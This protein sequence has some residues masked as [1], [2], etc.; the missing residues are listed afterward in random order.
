[1]KKLALVAAL[2]LFPAGAGAQ[3]TTDPR[4][5]AWLGCWELVLESSR[6]T[7][8]RLPPSRG[9]AT[10]PRSTPRP[11]ICVQPSPGGATFS[12]R[13]GTQTPVEQTVIA[14]GVD[15]PI[16]DGECQ[17]TQRSEWSRDGLSLFANADLTCAN[18]KGRRE[19]S[20]LAILG[21]NW[22]WID[23]HSVNISGQQTVRVRRYS[24]VDATAQTS[25][26][27]K[28]PLSL[29]DVKEASA[30]V[31]PRTLEAA[32]VETRSTFELSGKRL[33]Q[34]QDAGVPATVTDLMVALS[35]PDRF[36]IE[37][38]SRDDRA[39]SSPMLD[40]PFFLGWAF[41]YPMW[42]DDFGFYSPLYGPYSPYYYSPFAYSYLRYYD[43]HYFGGG[44][45]YMVIGDGD[46]GGSVPPRPSGTG[47]VV[48]GQGY[49]RLRPRGGEVS[50][51][52]DT[53]TSVNGGS[54]SGGSSSSSSGG[55]GSVSSQGFSSG[56]S[57]GDGGRTAQER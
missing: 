52:G 34:L 24:R 53:G 31:S 35:Y 25:R 28:Q 37:R 48:D 1:M 26:G 32:L 22:T 11:Q 42:S 33:I 6:D 57:G 47:R 43:P 38:P 36:V 18:D 4:W 7:T 5:S 40:D 51:R 27:R 2:S 14:D 16:V 41:G 56:G 13:V 50:P 23:I 30:K 17:G 19:V 29:D 39:P 54:S 46:G 15:H 21:P 45:S 10:Q 55:G 3:D 8:S 9:T 49:T 20:G 12:T 44:G